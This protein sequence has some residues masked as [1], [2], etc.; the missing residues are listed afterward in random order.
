MKKFVL[1]SFLAAAFVVALLSPY[2]L[3]S[4]GFNIMATAHSGV[5]TLVAHP[6]A[7]Q[8]AG[9]PVP[10]TA[11]P[12]TTPKHGTI[13]V[14]RAGSRTNI[15]YQSTKGYVGEDSFQFV[16]VANDAYAGT[17]TVTVTVK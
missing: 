8:I 11:K 7:S 10:Y 4:M 15:F 17:Y 13:S 14:V 5:K 1:S 2:A 9:Q 6:H 12:V 3:A 16:R